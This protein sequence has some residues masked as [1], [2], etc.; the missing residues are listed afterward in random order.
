MAINLLGKADSTLV[1]AATRASMA[2]APKD[3]SRTFESVSRNYHNTMMA[4]AKMWGDIAK[5]GTSMYMTYK[6]GQAE[7]K[8]E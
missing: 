8:L 4:S 7:K 1:T 5:A 6:A 3:Y 2:G